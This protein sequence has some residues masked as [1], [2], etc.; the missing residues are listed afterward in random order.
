MYPYL[1]ACSCVE[2]CY[3]GY[4]LNIYAVAFINLENYFRGEILRSK[5]TSWC[6]CKSVQ[7]MGYLGRSDSSLVHYITCKINGLCLIKLYQN[8]SVASSIFIPFVRTYWL[9][10]STR[11]A[12]E[13]FKTKLPN[14]NSLLHRPDQ[15]WRFNINGGEI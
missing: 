3:F 1:S 15:C 10:F 14:L 6:I 7:P 4:T 5:I 2:Y 9:K 11:F 12:H 8:Q 13:L